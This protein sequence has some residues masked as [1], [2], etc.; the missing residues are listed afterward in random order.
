MTPLPLPL[1]SL[2]CHEF[3]EGRKEGS[4]SL[5]YVERGGLRR[6]LYGREM[7]GDFGS[8]DDQC[9]GAHERRCCGGPQREETTRRPGEAGTSTAREM[10]GLPV[11]E[12]QLVCDDHSGWSRMAT[13]TGNA[14]Y[15]ARATFASRLSSLPPH[16]PLARSL[17]TWASL[18]FNPATAP[19]AAARS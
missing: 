9:D 14:V 12:F 17:A 18:A 1:N 4:C 3:K 13:L 2:I 16:V 15:V 6:S 5:Y 10:D 7:F 11:A 19:A 8:P